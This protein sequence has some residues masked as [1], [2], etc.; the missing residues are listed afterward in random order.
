[1]RKST[2]PRVD[3]NVFRNSANSTKSLNV[4]VK[5]FRGGIRL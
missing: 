5:F 3:R 4:G 2:N 1:M